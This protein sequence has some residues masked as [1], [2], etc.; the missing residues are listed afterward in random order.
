MQSLM[1][2]IRTLYNSREENL[3][4][5]NYKIDPEVTDT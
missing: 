1:E 2:T 5:Y 4:R 3:D